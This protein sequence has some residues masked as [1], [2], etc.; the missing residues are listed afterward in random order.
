[1]NRAQ[2]ATMFNLLSR[3]RTR[4]AECIKITRQDGVIYRFT[5]HDKP[6]RVKEPDGNSYIY[7][8]AS[9]FSLTSLET[10][11][12]LVVSNMDIDGAIDDDR[13]TE[14]D[15]RNGLFDH[16]NVELFL[17]YWANSKVTVLPL[18]TS[19]IGEIQMDGPKYKVDL[20]GIAQRL[21]Q[22]FV[23]A[24]SLECRYDF[25]DSCCTLDVA[26]F[27]NTFS[28]GTPESR[29]TFTVTGGSIPNVDN[30]YQWGLATWL[31]GNNAGV[32]MEI[33]RQ[34]DN[35]VQLF[36][37]MNSAI[38]GGDTLTMLAGCSKTWTQCGIYG[39]QV[40][41]GGEPFL[42]GND[43]LSRYPDDSPDET[44]DER[45]IAGNSIGFVLDG[46]TSSGLFGGEFD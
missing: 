13:I 45:G 41:F 32:R 43:I 12:G 18:R 26:D 11:T 46:I 31:T 19:W 8:S 44:E 17:A 6:F 2:F 37:P 1:M 24:T 3:T 10:S 9:S 25:C 22:T 27:T 21:A 4:Y 33:L 29:D 14:N 20:R 15:L 36:L 23:N 35:R 39:N 28:V 38:R 40:N 30:F 42:A 34:N 16:A 5:A 7:E